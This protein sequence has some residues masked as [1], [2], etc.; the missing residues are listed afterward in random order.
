[1]YGLKHGV[2]AHTKQ[3]AIKDSKIITGNVKQFKQENQRLNLYKNLLF[4]SW[5]SLK[6]LTLTWCKQQGSAYYYIYSWYL[7]K[8]TLWVVSKI[9]A[10]IL[11]KFEVMWLKWT[12][13]LTRNRLNLSVFALVGLC[14]LNC[15]FFNKF[16]KI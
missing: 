15:N 7:S 4:W 6:F 1:M 16:W 10:D 14:T 13:S 12:Y 3:Q 2:L 8:S 5:I 9:A 11:K